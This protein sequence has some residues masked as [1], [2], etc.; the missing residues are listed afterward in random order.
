MA[1]AKAK[2]KKVVGKLFAKAAGPFHS[3]VVRRGGTATQREIVVN[4]KIRLSWRTDG[5]SVPIDV[6]QGTV[7][8]HGFVRGKVGATWGFV[9]I[10]PHEEALGGGKLATLGVEAFDTEVTIP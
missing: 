1:I 4:K 7:T 8:L 9:L 6:P 3:L 2:L 5:T 10:Q